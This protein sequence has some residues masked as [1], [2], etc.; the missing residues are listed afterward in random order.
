MRR[1]EF[2]QKSRRCKNQLE[3]LKLKNINTGI[4]DSIDRI[5][6]IGLELVEF[7]IFFPA[8]KC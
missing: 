2:Q 1:E 8:Q 5:Y 7:Y 6:T 4:K 3:I